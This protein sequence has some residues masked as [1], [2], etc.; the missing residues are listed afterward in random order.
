MADLGHV[1][2]ESTGRRD[3]WTALPDRECRS[4]VVP[5]EQSGPAWSK[6]ADLDRV[7]ALLRRTRDAPVATERST[8]AWGE[9]PVIVELL[10]HLLP[11]RAINLEIHQRGHIR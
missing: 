5:S 10:V 11:A 6:H 1:P 2:F 3:Q 8:D 9:A 7:S 4:G